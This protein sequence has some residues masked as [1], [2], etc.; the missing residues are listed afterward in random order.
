[1]QDYFLSWMILRC[2][3]VGMIAVFPVITASA[4]PPPP[5]PRVDDLVAK[6]VARDQN[7]QEQLR[8]MQ[9]RETIHGEQLDAHGDVTQRQDTQMIVQPGASEPFKVI[10]VRGDRIPAD[11]DEAVR[12]AKGQET[13][14]RKHDFSLRVLAARFNISYVGLGSSLGVPAYILSFEPKPNQPY[15]DQTEK[16]LNQL[17]GRLWI[18]PRTD[19]V[20]QT[21]ATL[22]QPVTVAWIFAKITRLDFKYQ[23]RSTASIFGPS[24]LQVSVEVSTPLWSVRQRQTIDLTDFTPMG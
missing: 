7:T 10:S 14:R 1:M 4:T 24:G 18:D 21:E 6:V 2:A 9:Y 20:L 8:S 11:P 12:Q 13:D 22:V 3:A 5:A 23:M 15:R 19:V 16:V 17:H